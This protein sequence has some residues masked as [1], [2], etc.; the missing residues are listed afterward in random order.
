MK[1]L[2]DSESTT[3]EAYYSRGS[4]KSPAGTAAKH[5]RD[6]RSCSEIPEVIQQQAG[7]TQHKTQC[8]AEEQAGED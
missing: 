8:P 5:D 6:E 1:F 7:K 4:S 2:L 3:P